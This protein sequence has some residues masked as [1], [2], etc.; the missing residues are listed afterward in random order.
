MRHRCVAMTARAPGRQAFVN[1]AAFRSS[2][3]FIYTLASLLLISLF[4]LSRYHFWCPQWATRAR[5]RPFKNMEPVWP[6]WLLWKSSGLPDG[7]NPTRGG[8]FWIIPTIMLTQ[9]CFKIALCIGS[10][11]GN[12]RRW[13]DCRWSAFRSSPNPTYSENVTFLQKQV[14]KKYVEIND[15]CKNRDQWESIHQQAREELS[16]HKVRPGREIDTFS[17]LHAAY[18]SLHKNN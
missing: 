3:T 9:S 10:C 17:C 16:G 14:K 2:R 11:V 18:I 12:E 6:E 8:P 15:L 5:L 7:P 4:L 13:R 1:V